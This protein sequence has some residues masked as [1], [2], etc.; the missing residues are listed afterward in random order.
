MKEYQDLIGKII[1]AVA[2]VIAGY[3]IAQAGLEIADKLFPLGEMIR[4]GLLQ[5]SSAS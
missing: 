1:I 3:L 5:S 2:I 4:D